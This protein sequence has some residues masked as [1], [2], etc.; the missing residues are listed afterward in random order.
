MKTCTASIQFYLISNSKKGM[1]QMIGGGG[2]GEYLE[3]MVKMDG[4]GKMYE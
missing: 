4:R 1:K 3:Q 2:V